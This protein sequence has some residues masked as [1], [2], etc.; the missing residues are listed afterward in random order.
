ML[1]ALAELA[2]GYKSMTRIAGRPTVS[3]VVADYMFCR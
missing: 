2:V 3:L 1:L